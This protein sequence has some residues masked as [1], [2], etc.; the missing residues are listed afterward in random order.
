[1]DMSTL[2]ERLGG[3]AAIEA[4]VVRFYDKVMADPSLSPF[5]HGLDMDAQIQKQIAFMTLAFGGPN[6]Y[7]GRDLREAHKP[8]LE[9]GLNAEHFESIGRYLKATLEEL[10]VEQTVINQVLGVVEGTRSD[11][12]DQ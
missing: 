12:L 11:V 5:F 6:G 10:G 3:Q 9:R 1:M 7:T 8:L 4:A 2:Y